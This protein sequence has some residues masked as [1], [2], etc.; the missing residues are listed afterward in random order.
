MA[1]K[2]TLRRIR[3]PTSIP[4]HGKHIFE[5]TFAHTNTSKKRYRTKNCV[6]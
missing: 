2:G 4:F 5:S 3:L 6:P 1:N